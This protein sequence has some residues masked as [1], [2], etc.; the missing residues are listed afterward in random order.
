MVSTPE[1]VADAIWDAGPGGRAERYVPRAYWMTAAAR[2]V[3][4]RV[5]RRALRGGGGTMTP[6]TGG[7]ARPSE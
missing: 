2:A 6:A 5:V 4:P 3:A 7:D 1:K